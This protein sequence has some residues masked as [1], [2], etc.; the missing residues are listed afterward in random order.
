MCSYLAIVEVHRVFILYNV[1][2]AGHCINFVCIIPNK[3]I[4]KTSLSKLILVTVYQYICSWF[5][6]IS[7]TFLGDMALAGMTH[8]YERK[9]LHDMQQKTCRLHIVSDRSNLVVKSTIFNLINDKRHPII[10]IVHCFPCRF[11]V[12]VM[13]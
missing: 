11:Q 10:N 2:A 8:G 13:Q 9:T 7:H 5:D 1:F 3:L 6:R 12:D 4:T